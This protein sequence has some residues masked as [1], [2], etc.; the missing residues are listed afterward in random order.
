MGR[1]EEL[2][3]ELDKAKAELDDMQQAAS[4]AQPSE[5]LAA[6]LREL[7]DMREEMEMLSDYLLKATSDKRALRSSNTSLEGQLK[8]QDAHLSHTKEALEE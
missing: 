3:R 5:V 4:G 8:A 1:E 2:S 7:Q 6:A